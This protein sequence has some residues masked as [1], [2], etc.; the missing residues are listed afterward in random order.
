L[1]RGGNWENVNILPLNHFRIIIA[2]DIDYK[3]KC[4][5]N[6]GLQHVNMPEQFHQ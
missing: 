1:Y 4:K 6:T 3:F 2:I 5:R